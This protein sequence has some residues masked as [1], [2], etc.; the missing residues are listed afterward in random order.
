M[1]LVFLDKLLA[2]CETEHDCDSGRNYGSILLRYNPLCELTYQ[3]LMRL[4]DAA[5]DRGDALAV[6]EKCARILQDHLGVEPSGVTTQLYQQ[7]RSETLSSPI[8]SSWRVDART[9]N[10]D[11][12][13]RLGQ[14]QNVLRHVEET[15]SSGFGVLNQ[16]LAPNKP[17]AKRGEGTA[18]VNFFEKKTLRQTAKRRFR[19]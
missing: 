9:P 15:L 3:R 10:D 2:R 17:R 7:M 14:D 19:R 5:G 4:Y 16:A 13:T 6:Y 12:A 1:Y 18:S 8:S 11:V